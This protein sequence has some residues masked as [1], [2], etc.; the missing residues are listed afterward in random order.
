ML[1]SPPF[2]SKLKDV[3]D[4]RN[5]IDLPA[6]LRFFVTDTREGRT[7]GREHQVHGICTDYMGEV[8]WLLFED[9]KFNDVNG[10]TMSELS[11]D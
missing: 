2:A 9:G 11:L 10:F 5:V 3:P 6:R 1:K 8:R 7:W 4:H